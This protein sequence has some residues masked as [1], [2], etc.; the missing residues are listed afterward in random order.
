MIV[1]TGDQDKLN[2]KKL[3]TQTKKDPNKKTGLFKIIQA[4]TQNIEKSFVYHY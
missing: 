1:V 4:S 2:L 3:G